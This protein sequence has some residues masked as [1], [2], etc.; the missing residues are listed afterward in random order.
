MPKF[1]YKAIDPAGKDSSGIVEAAT[2]ADA[3]KEIGRRGYYLTDM[4]PAGIG[5]ELITR[6][7]HQREEYERQEAR[8][9]EHQKKRQTRQRLV[10]RYRD[11]RT[12]YGMCLALNPRENSFHLERTDKKGIT[13]GQTVQVRYTDLKAVYYVK[14]FDGKYDKTLRYKEWTPEGHEMVIEFIDGE[15]LRG[16]ALVRVDMD[17][18][19]FHVVP[20]DPTTNNITVLVERSAIKATY[21]PEEW[22]AKRAADHEARKKQ[23]D[24]TDLTQ[25]ETTGDFYFETRNYTAAI[26]QYALAARK[27]PQSGRIRK[28]ILAAQFNIGI[29]HIKR[30]E[31]KEAEECMQKV[32][33]LDP[34]NTH[35]QKKVLQLRKIMERSGRPGA[36]K[37]FEDDL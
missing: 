1:V 28:K 21:T 32:L 34:H 9:E 18:L 15:I 36:V 24:G 23:P 10:V 8:R 12:D 22:E 4:R 25:E 5:D 3:V 30:R 35:A 20:D 19:R 37:S 6:W 7:K 26:E 31:Y 13:T 33:K 14:S 11:G 29:Q 16:H 27:A 17:D 2:E